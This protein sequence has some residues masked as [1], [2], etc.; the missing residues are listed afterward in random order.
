MLLIIR[1]HS[2]NDLEKAKNYCKLNIRSNLSN[3]SLQAVEKLKNCILYESINLCT[4]LCLKHPEASHSQNERHRP[5]M[6]CD[7]PT[8]SPVSVIIRHSFD[9]FDANN[10]VSTR[11]P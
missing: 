4:S 10:L 7:D 8:L 11:E 2:L 6:A 1:Q 5:E 9:L 3:P